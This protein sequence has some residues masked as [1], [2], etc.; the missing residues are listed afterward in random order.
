MK[1]AN[2]R[3]LDLCIEGAA[4]G[5]AYVGGSELMVCFPLRVFN[6][7]S[8]FRRRA[9]EER[10]DP[11]PRPTD[12]RAWAAVGNNTS[13]PARKARRQT[14]PCKHGRE[15]YTCKECGG[16]GICVHQ[17][18]REYCKECGGSQICV[19]GRIRYDCRECGGGRFCLHGKR[20]NTG[21]CK[22]GC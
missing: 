9:L 4:A 10:R 18:M 2:C 8:C 6:F 17:R 22:H 1:S 20:R 5:G 3:P 12:V 19:H 7:R 21:A 14:M 16:G 11:P 15:R 13:R